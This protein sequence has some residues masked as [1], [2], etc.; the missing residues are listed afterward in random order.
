M[1]SLKMFR[2]NVMGFLLSRY[3]THTKVSGKAIR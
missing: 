1:L 3:V 2:L